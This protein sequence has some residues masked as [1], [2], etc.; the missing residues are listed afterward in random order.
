LH[1]RIKR[2]G[3]TP[4]LSFALNPQNHDNISTFNRVF[5]SFLDAQPAVDKLGKS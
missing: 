2:E 5:E 3:K 4:R 1:I